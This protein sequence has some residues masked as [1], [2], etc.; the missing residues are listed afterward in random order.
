MSGYL[1]FVRP[2]PDEALIRVSS[3]VSTRTWQAL[4][5]CSNYVRGKGA[6]LVPWTFA[7]VQITSASTETFR[8]RVKPRTSAVE[9][10]WGFLVTAS[11]S[12]YTVDI[13]APASGTAVVFDVIPTADDIVPYFVTETLASK[14]GTEA[15]INCSIK[16]TGG[17]VNVVGICCYEQD[18]PL[19]NED[20]TDMGV[21]QP[22]LAAGQPIIASTYESL[23]GVANTVLNGSKIDG[24]RVGLLHATWGDTGVSRTTASYQDMLT[25]PAPVLAAKRYRTDTTADV[26]INVYAKVAAGAGGNVRFTAASG[27]THTFTITNTTA[28]W[29]TSNVLTVDCEDVDSA[30]GRQTAA[31]PSWDTIQVAFQGDG[32][33]ALTVYHWSVWEGWA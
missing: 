15:E 25:L 2:E 17:T 31:S 27:D 16:A 23:A 7:D 3:P 1:P 4:A 29:Q 22:T 18:R 5:G 12:G 32:T 9:R 11:S 6:M 24:R 13:K 28:A 20:A 30:D 21:D 10:I 8:F 14:S 19:L 26:S 33:N